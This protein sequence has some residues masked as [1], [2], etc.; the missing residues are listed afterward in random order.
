MFVSKDPINQ[1]YKCTEELVFETKIGRRDM[2]PS[3]HAYLH[4]CRN[5][6]FWDPH[7]HN[8]CKENRAEFIRDREEGNFCLYFTFKDTGDED[9]T[10]EAEQAKAR[11][12]AL[13]GGAP[14][15]AKK[16]PQNVDDAREKLKK[17]FK[18]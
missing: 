14:A 8:Q 9:G 4:C 5:C 7:V 12:A 10:S 15:E 2:C 16:A 13:F 11:L 6:T 18:D 1:C 17:L 3:C